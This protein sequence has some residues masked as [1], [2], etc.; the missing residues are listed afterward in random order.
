MHDLSSEMKRS[1]PKI[2]IGLV[3]YNGAG[4]IRDV[5]DSIVKQPY[6]NIELIVVDGGSTDGTQNVLRKYAE[7]ISV[8][9]SEPDKGI[10][11][12]MNKV[13]SLATGDWLIF[14]GCDD[15]LFDM[16]D[17]L[18]NMA[19]LMTNP[20]AVYYGDV[21][22]RS[23][24]KIYGGK[25][26]KYRLLQK[27]FCHQAMFYPSSAYK[28]YTY[29]LDYKWYA[30]YIYNLKLLGDAVPF[31]Y[32][33]VLVS[34]FNDKGASSRGDAEFEKSKINLIRSSLGTKYALIEILRRRKEAWV[35]K[36]LEVNTWVVK[37]AVKAWLCI[38]CAVITL[39]DKTA[40]T[41][42][43][44]LKSLFPYSFWKYFQSIWRWLRKILTG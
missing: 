36:I 5:L 43:I 15:V 38:T 11:D 41:I 6:R 19:A 34:I 14:L 23:S 33:S 22:V 2:S 3:V 29:S 4:H 20:D 7:H 40:I 35:E 13:C 10:Y 26:S 8:M 30:D 42:G 1:S 32:T 28:K 18:G 9:V 17:M 25:F 24:G 21:V 16:L 12:A 27:N 37:W 31:E 39:V 44:V